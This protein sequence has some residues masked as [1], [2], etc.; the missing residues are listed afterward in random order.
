MEEVVDMVHI[1][2][3]HLVDL[4]MTNQM[5]VSNGVQLQRFRF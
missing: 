1:D 5:A 3:C 4:G 2:Y